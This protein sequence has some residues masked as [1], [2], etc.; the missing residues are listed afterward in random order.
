[1]EDGNVGLFIEMETF[2]ELLWI[3]IWGF[4]LGTL[5]HIFVSFQRKSQK[6]SKIGIFLIFIS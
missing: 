3:Q 1:M 5:M 4:G 2:S 6:F